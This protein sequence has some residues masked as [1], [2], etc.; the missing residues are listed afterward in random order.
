MIFLCWIQC[1]GVI[2][3]WV[4]YNLVT[5]LQVLLM[6]TSDLDSEEEKDRAALD[7]L[8]STLLHEL[9]LS[10]V[11]LDSVAGRS[12]QFEVKLVYLRLLSVLLSRTKAGTKPSSEVEYDSVL[13]VLL[14]FYL[15][16]TNV[17]TKSVFVIIKNLIFDTSVKFVK[18]FICV[19][20]SFGDFLKWHFCWHI[21]SWLS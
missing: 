3:L 12:K 6:L 14:V 5:T 21:F 8:L 7:S 2:L 10:S 11:S 15:M 18:S 16:D 9:D 13:M 1:D 4:V 19:S 20:E 17:L